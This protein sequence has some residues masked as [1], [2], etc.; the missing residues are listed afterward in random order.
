[1]YFY[2]MGVLCFH[3]IDRGWFCLTVIVTVFFFVLVV[4][5]VLCVISAVSETAFALSNTL[6]K[7]FVILGRIAIVV[8]IVGLAVAFSLSVMTAEPQAWQAGVAEL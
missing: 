5:F 8:G 6:T 7:V 2:L 4:G 3:G 1:M